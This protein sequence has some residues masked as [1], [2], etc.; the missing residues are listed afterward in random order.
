MRVG[1]RGAGRVGT[2]RPPCEW[3]SG[4]RGRRVPLF[5][6]QVRHVARAALGD[7]RSH[8]VGAAKPD[9]STSGCAA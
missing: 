8:A 6:C 7:W 3:L 1:V 2:W 5:R 4:R 9:A